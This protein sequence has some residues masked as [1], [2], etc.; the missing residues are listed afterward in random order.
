[1]WTYLGGPLFSLLHILLYSHSQIMSVCIEK[2]KI[3]YKQVIRFNVRVQQ[4]DSIVERYL[5]QTKRVGK[6]NFKDV[7]YN[8]KKL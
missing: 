7:I 8:M 6:Y 2:A 3:I 4:G 1:M 5:V